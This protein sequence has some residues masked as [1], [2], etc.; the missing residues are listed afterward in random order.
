M[1]R[2][3]SRKVPLSFRIW[4]FFG[5]LLGVLTISAGVGTRA[6]RAQSNCTPTQCSN[7]HAYAQFVCRN[8]GGLFDFSCPNGGVPNDDFFFECM[9]PGSPEGL[10]DCDDFD[11]S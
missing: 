6:V 10:Y 8:Y 11:P 7:A 5:I 9:S 4:V 3:I 2:P 1:E